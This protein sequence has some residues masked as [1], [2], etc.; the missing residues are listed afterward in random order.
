MGPDLQLQKLQPGPGGCE[1][2]LIKLFIECFNI[3]Q[4][5]IKIFGKGAQFNNVAFH[6]NT[7]CK[8]L[9]FYLFK[10]SIKSSN[11]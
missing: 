11:R 7:G 2:L 6:W 1:P 10:E 9:L 8:V 5:F 4:H 3:I